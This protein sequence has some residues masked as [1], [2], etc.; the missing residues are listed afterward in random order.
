MAFWTF[1]RLF[2]LGAPDGVMPEHRQPPGPYPETRQ[3]DPM[4]HL[5]QAHHISDNSGISTLPTI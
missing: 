4:G 2:R 1:S 3:D 5:F